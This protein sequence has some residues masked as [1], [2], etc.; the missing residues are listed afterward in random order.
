MLAAAS[1]SF[2]TPRTFQVVDN[3]GT[4]LNL[5]Y[6]AY[7]YVGARFNPVHASTYQASRLAVARSD[8]GGRVAIPA[9]F[10]IHRPFPI[11]GHPSLWMEFVYVPQMHNAWGQINKGSPSR[12][13][14]FEI[15]A[16]RR[17]ATVFDLG[18]QP[19]L[20]EGTLRS[21]SSV[22]QRLVST[23]PGEAP[24]RKADPATAALTL[25][26]MGHFRQE[27]ESFLARYRDVARPMPEM[28]QHLLDSERRGWT[29]MVEADLARSPRW[30]DEISRLFRDEVRLLG[31]WEKELR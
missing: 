30:G 22:I 8:R 31:R 24:L 11:E 4:P 2:S 20:W 15:D 26:L 6:I 13:G 9:A 27:Y 16:T 21:L 28:P 5:A 18:G 10:H 3:A 7:S 23:S 1:I 14:N 12:P 19:Q 29:E 17:R 25:E